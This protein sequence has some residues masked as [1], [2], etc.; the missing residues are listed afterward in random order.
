V[1]KAEHAAVIWVF[2]KNYKLLF[3]IAKLQQSKKRYPV[4]QK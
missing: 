2:G 3:L 4:C 1:I